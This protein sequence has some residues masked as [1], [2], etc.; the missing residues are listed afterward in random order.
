MNLFSVGEKYFFMNMLL[1]RVSI[2]NDVY[3]NLR[4]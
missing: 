2:N 1:G 4:I 3:S